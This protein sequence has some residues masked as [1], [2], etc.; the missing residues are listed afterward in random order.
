VKTNK[1]TERLYI[2]TDIENT[3]GDIDFVVGVGVY[4]KFGKVGYRGIKAEEIYLYAIG[5]S[6]LQYD[7]NMILKEAIPALNNGRTIWPIRQFVSRCKSIDCL[8]EKVE[9]SLEKSTLDLLSR[10]KR[11]AI[12]EGKFIEYINM[13]CILEHYKQYGL[14]KTISDIFKIN[15][16]KIN[17]E[18]LLQ[19]IKLAIK[20]EPTLLKGEKHS[21][22]SNFKKC[23]TLWDMLVYSGLADN[24]IKELNKYNQEK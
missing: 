11:K 12:I 13:P 19:F 18:D 6:D 7:D 14:N 22:R 16:E 8:N 23:I 20:D 17:T 2:A 24:K 3:D 1:P 21:L 10:E 15:F 9:K 4:G 5:E